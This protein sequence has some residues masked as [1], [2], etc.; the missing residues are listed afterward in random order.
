MS[1]GDKVRFR[2]AGQGA[3]VAVPVPAGVAPWVSII[4]GLCRRS[5]RP[6][7]LLVGADICG[8]M[9]FNGRDRRGLF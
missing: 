2:S 4:S 8:K 3:V 1:G 6:E 7:E 9:G 5:I